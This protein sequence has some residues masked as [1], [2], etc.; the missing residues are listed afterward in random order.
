MRSLLI[1]V[2]LSFL[3]V[4]AWAHCNSQRISYIADQANIRG[5]E[6]GLAIAVARQTSAC[7]AG[8]RSRDKSVGVMS[9]RQAL[10]E[11][12]APEKTCDLAEPF[13]NVDL[14]IE[15]LATVLDRYP[16]VETA[17]SVYLSGREVPDRKTARTIQAIYRDAYGHNGMI[18]NQRHCHYNLD[19]D[20]FGPRCHHGR[21]RPI[22]E[23]ERGR[24][25][26][27]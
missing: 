25:K 27:W 26:R 17:L 23:L 3:S 9:V 18:R 19:L 22:A 16:D 7:R 10:V 5:V 1:I 20:D 15:L 12:F 6:P 8:Y 13:S 4:N 11:R 21:W 14:G 2:I 24:A